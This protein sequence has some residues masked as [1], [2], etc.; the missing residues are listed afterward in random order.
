MLTPD[1][2]EIDQAIA[3]VRGRIV[4]RGASRALVDDPR[5]L[6]DALAIG[7]PDQPSLFELRRSAE[8]LAQAEGPPLRTE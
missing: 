6:E 3:L 8:A 5:L 7:G 1:D 2:V 4:V